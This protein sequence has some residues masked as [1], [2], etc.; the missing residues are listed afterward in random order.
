MNMQNGLTGLMVACQKDLVDIAK[1]LLEAK[2]DTDMTEVVN[3]YDSNKIVQWITLYQ[4]KCHHALLLS[5]STGRT[6]LFFS[7]IQGN[8]E[9]IKL[10]LIH[11]ADVDIRD[12]VGLIVTPVHLYVSYLY[13][14]LPDTHNT[15]NLFSLSLTYTQL[16]CMTLCACSHTHAHNVICTH[17]RSHLHT[18]WSYSC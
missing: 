2:A 6:A 18:D 15:Q 13:C 1:A 5:Q 12:K 8:V 9:I 10:L 16:I 14:S 3:N 7:A 17:T 11:G 4:R